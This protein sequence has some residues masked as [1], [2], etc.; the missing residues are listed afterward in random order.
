MSEDVTSVNFKNEDFTVILF[1]LITT[2]LS[3][4]FNYFFFSPKCQAV[5]RKLFLF[6]LCFS[7]VETATPVVLLWKRDS[8]KVFQKGCTFVWEE[9][10]LADTL[11]EENWEP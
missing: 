7:L 8:Q 1:Y 5:N 4:F 6:L 11:R 3:I 9:V 2:K 10:P